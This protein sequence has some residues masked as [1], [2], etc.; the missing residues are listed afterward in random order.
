MTQQKRISEKELELQNVTSRVNTVREFFDKAIGSST[1]MPSIAL[2]L[3]GRRQDYSGV[4]IGDSD[5]KRPMTL[6]FNPKYGG[7]DED[8]VLMRMIQYYRYY[9]GASTFEPKELGTWAG[10]GLA[11]TALIFCH[12]AFKLQNYRT[13]IAGVEGTE[14]Q[15]QR[16][17]RAARLS[18]ERLLLGPDAKV[19]E[20]NKTLDILA[21]RKFDFEGVCRNNWD[22]I[23]DA[24]EFGK[25]PI[26]EGTLAM[27]LFASYDFDMERTIKTLLTKKP[28]AV[29][30]EAI[31]IA[32]EDQLLRMQRAEY[33]G[34]EPL[35]IARKLKILR[36]PWQWAELYD[37]IGNGTEAQVSSDAARSAVL[38]T[39]E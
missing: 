5:F 20:I 9:Y 4:W 14:V 1:P 13:A 2:D 21:G 11:H 12:Y 16:F 15:K 34:K 8:R 37:K 6:Q 17:G 7:T 28:R 36:R 10:Q 18:E 24:F 39:D 29:L 22:A 33:D 30:L 32:K 23:S 35:G 25:N 31:G 26:E 19:D 27:I 38:R 3:R